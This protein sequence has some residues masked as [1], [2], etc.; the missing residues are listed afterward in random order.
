MPTTAKITAK[1]DSFALHQFERGNYWNNT[2][3]IVDNATQRGVFVDPYYDCL[4]AFREQL[5]QLSRPLDAI[6]LTHA[7]IDH[8]WGID[9]IR[10]EFPDAQ[11]LVHAAGLPLILAEDIP[12]LCGGIESLE[13]CCEQMGCPLYKPV[14]PTGFITPGEPLIIGETTF[15]VL[16]TPGH[17]PGHI[18]FLHGDTLISGDLLFMGDV[19]F[20]H[21][22]GSNPKIL[23]DTLLDVILPLGDHINVHPGHGPATTV[24]RERQK[25]SFILEAFKARA[26]LSK[27]GR[28]YF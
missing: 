14:T 21:I 4:D 27:R 12:A 3:L 25:N 7:H 6:W 2:Y 19:G 1:T 22:P 5:N 10:S 9:H 20:T 23:A 15:E 8:V 18:A 11:V 28:V 16:D 26:A 24:A 17:C 13:S